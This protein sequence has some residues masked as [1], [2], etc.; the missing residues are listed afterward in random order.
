VFNKMQPRTL[1]ELQNGI[2][3]FLYIGCMKVNVIHQQRMPKWITL[4]GIHTLFVDNA[5]HDIFVGL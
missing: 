1:R 2:V 3:I 5:R 4:V